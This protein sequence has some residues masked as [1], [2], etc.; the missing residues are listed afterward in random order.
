MVVTWLFVCVCVWVW[1]Q[2]IAWG[3]PDGDIAGTI[4]DSKQPGFFS[5]QPAV[6]A[7]KSHNSIPIIKKKSSVVPYVG[8]PL[9]YQRDL[10]LVRLKKYILSPAVLA[11]LVLTQAVWN[12]AIIGWIV[13]QADGSWWI[14]QDH[15]HISC[16]SLSL[17]RLKHIIGNISVSICAG[18]RL[19]LCLLDLSTLSLV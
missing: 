19:Q 2:D 12:I 13:S 10:T 3:Q 4:S 5:E 6:L 15:D 1:E 9:E 17:L 14:L 11:A 18:C 16:L 7:M 8:I